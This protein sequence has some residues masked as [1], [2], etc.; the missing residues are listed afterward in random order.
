MVGTHHV[1]DSSYTDLR[2]SL[3]LLNETQRRLTHSGGDDSHVRALIPA[4]D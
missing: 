1:E 2:Q 4:S 3:R